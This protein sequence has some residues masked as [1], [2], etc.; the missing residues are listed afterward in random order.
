MVVWLILNL[1]ASSSWV[2]M[3][4]F[5]LALSLGTEFRTTVRFPNISRVV[6]VGADEG[7]S[8]V[9]F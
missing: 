1:A 7:D 5:L 2:L 4:V 3:M 9:V 6:V 8:L